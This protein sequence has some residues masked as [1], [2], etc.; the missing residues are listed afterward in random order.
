[1]TKIEGFEFKGGKT[2]CLLIHG[3]GGSPLE[4]RWLGE[5]LAEN[6]YTVI[7]PLLPGHGTSY[8]DMGRTGWRDWHRTS[9]EA[10]YRLKHM[11]DNVFVIGLSM[12]GAIGLSMAA[13]NG[14]SGVVSLA[15]PLFIND[16]RIKFL[17]ILRYILKYPRGGP[18]DLKDVSKRK[19]VFSYKRVPMRCVEELLTS[20][21]DLKVKLPRIKMPVLLV[22][23]RVDHIVPPKNVEVIYILVH[24]RV[25]HIVPPKNV[26]VI[27]N[28][29]GSQ[30]KRLVYLDNSYHVVTVDYDRE[31]VKDEILKFINSKR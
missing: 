24:A 18:P 3:F 28:L 15:A 12:G 11:C 2:G 7:A 26:E 5:R 17:P 31:I 4:L 8:Y 21:S 6:N 22:H 1:M 29:L 14:F 23:A 10:F 13:E 19:E 16:W 27:Y 25:D 9:E 30:D 20:L